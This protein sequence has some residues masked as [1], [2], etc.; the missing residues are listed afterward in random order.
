MKF[1]IGDTVICIKYKGARNYGAGWK[2]GFIFKIT[3]INPLGRSPN[4]GDVYF[5]TERFEGYGVYEKGLK[6]VKGLT[7]S[8]RLNLKNE[9]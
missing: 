5:Y 4:Y 7:Q 8:Q 1:N 3:R 9:I 2:E 6:L